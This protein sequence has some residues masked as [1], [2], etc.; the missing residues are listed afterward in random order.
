MNH[1]YESFDVLNPVQLEAKLENDNNSLKDH[2]KMLQDTIRALKRENNIGSVNSSTSNNLPDRGDLGGNTQEYKRT[3]EYGSG[4]NMNSRE[5]ENEPTGNNS[6]KFSFNKARPG[7]C[8]D[9]GIMNSNDSIHRND[10]NYYGS[11]LDRNSFNDYERNQYL[12]PSNDKAYSESKL[13]QDHLNSDSRHIPYNPLDRNIDNYYKS[14]INPT[15][16]SLTPN[17]KYSNNFQS[18]H[19]NKGISFKGS[20]EFNYN[21]MSSEDEN[22]NNQAYE[23]KGQNSDDLYRQ[24]LMEKS[25]S[26]KHEIRISNEEHPQVNYKPYP[27]MQDH[28]I[29]KPIENLNEN[30]LKSDDP[31]D[32]PYEEQ[33]TLRMKNM[34]QSHINKLR[35]E[36]NQHNPGHSQ[37]GQNFQNNPNSERHPSSQ[38]A[39]KTDENLEKEN[40]NKMQRYKDKLNEIDLLNKGKD[41]SFRFYREIIAK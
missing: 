24:Y 33:Y 1:N 12:N 35:N 40:K 13:K 14:P 32:K 8:N 26:N 29:I 2:I 22:N 41:I 30:D 10:Q 23:Q 15:A 37:L 31:K 19:F 18:A 11:N 3:V 38:I 16:H 6:L 20:S 21:Y 5:L 34:Y 25:Q 7:V 36:T 4:Y 27:A 9:R 17:E 39:E 28:E